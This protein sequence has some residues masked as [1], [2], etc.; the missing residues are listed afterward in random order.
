MDRTSLKDFFRNKWVRVVLIADAI[1][2]LI[3]IIL[4]IVNASK[5]ATLV[6]DV[7]PI[8]ATISIN[9][10]GNYIN[11]TY[12][13][14]PGNYKI[15]ITRE[16]LDGKSFDITIDKGQIATITAYLTSGGD[17]SFY[18]AKDQRNSFEKLRNMIS[19]D[20]NNTTDHDDSAK[21][22]V[23]VLYDDFMR[24]GVLPIEDTLYE[25]TD[26]GRRLVRDI[27]IRQS[28][29]QSCETW[30]CIEALMLKTDNQSIVLKD[31]ENNG[32][33]VEDYEIKYK[34]Y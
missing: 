3:L 26:A 30:L 33:T 20:T 16:G 1:V 6:L 7:T 9:G 17:I 12:D 11:G 13:L 28:S 22:A 15:D 29:D 10:K 24:L 2:V 31:L 19:A 34:V 18:K 23:V 14:S 5:T 25:G 4:A 21:E 8:D 27:T 32:F